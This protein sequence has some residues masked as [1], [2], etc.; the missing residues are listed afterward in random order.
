M[1]QCT[2]PVVMTKTTISNSLS[3]KATPTTTPLSHFALNVIHSSILPWLVM[4]VL[5]LINRE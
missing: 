2:V 3:H 5:L 4:L 1:K